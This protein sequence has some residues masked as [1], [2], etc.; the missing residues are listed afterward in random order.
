MKNRTGKLIAISTTFVASLGLS[1]LV[2]ADPY[3]E[4]TP[5]PPGGLQPGVENDFSGTYKFWKDSAT[6]AQYAKTLGA[7]EL[8]KLNAKENDPPVNEELHG[9]HLAMDEGEEIY[10]KLNAKGEFAACLGA[11]NGS[12]DGLRAKHYP[13]YDEKLGHIV[14]LEEMIERCAAKQ[15]EKLVNGSHNNSAV[16]IYIASFSN[17]MPLTIDLSDKHLKAA[18]DRGRKLF[19]QRGGWTNFSCATCHVSLVGKHLRGQTPTT[20]YGDAAHWPTFRVKDEIQSL[21]VRFTECN[22]NAGV[23]P[24]KV[25]SKEYTDLEVF[26]SGLS[27]GYPVV[28]PSLR[29]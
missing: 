15:G 6:V 20:P 27:N 26:L 3:R 12:L 23:Q 11:K 29:Y 2:Q 4:Y 19:T 22:R 18:F 8:W 9:G 7:E 21:H 10:N 5:L 28:A 16:S 14:G 17:G 25:G 13:R 24:L 1:T